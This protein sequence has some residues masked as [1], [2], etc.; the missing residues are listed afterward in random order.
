MSHPYGAFCEDF[1]IN[2]LIPTRQA[3]FGESITG[4]LFQKLFS[5]MAKVNWRESQLHAMQIKRTDLQ[6]LARIAAAKSV[7]T[8]ASVKD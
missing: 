3:Y 8:R 6:A 5:K 7:L 1:Y 2:I 4:N